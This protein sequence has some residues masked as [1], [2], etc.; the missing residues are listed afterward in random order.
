[1][2]PFAAFVAIDWSDTTHDICLVDGATGTK[3]PFLLKHTPEELD[4]WATALRLRVGGRPIAVCLEQ[5]RGPLI[6][7]LLKYDF[8]VL[9]P[10]HPTTLA[11]YREACSPSRAKDDPRH[12]DYRLERLVHHRDRL[13][14]W[15]PDHAK[16]R[17]L[18]DL[19]QHRRRLVNDR[20]RLSNRVTALLKAYSPQVLH[21]CDDVRTLLVCDFLLRWP[22]GEALNK[23]RPATLDKFV[24]EQNS[25]R[26]ETISHRIAASKEAVPLTT[27][28]AV[29][30]ASVLRINAL[31]TQMKT[32][33]EA[34]RACDHEI[35][36]LGS[37]HEDSHLLA[38]LPGAGTV[39]AARLTAA[40][41]PV[42][43]RWTTVD[44][45]LCF[46]GIAPVLERSGK[47]TWVRWR[48]FGPKFLRQSFHEY[49]GESGH[50][51]FWAKAYYLSQRA[52]GKRHQAAVR[53]LAF[54]W[55]RIIYK[56]WQ[57]RTPYSEV[58]SLESLRQ[59]GS[60]LLAFA[61]NHPSC[62]SHPS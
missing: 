18:Q 19:V 11:K 12:A 1:M 46:S 6:Y 9:Y 51:S 56:C 28:Q 52:R 25:G 57:T 48:Y 4:A 62:P 61:A 37:T 58:R 38:S 31:A 39:Y 7:A 32:T 8:L 33:I 27:D 59:K 3:E 5:S 35:E 14:A 44:E 55:I 10:I 26:R 49:A 43:D 16:T 60:P 30:H 45:L 53:A 24:H 20:T 40:M 34:I 22:T 42:R 13:K 15:R 17:T 23:A 21:W 2:E 54:K 50:H 29:I 47:S 36:P 41:G